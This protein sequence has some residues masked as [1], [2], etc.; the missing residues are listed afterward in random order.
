MTLSRGICRF[1]GQFAIELVIGTCT[2]FFI[3]AEEITTDLGAQNNIHLCPSF[4]GSE[5]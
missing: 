3:A 1:G 4:R 2:K 5:V